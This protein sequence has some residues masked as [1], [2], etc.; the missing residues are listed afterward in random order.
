MYKTYIITHSPDYLLAQIAT[1]VLLRQ[2]FDVAWAVDSKEDLPAPHNDIIRTYEKRGGNLNGGTKWVIEQLQLMYDNANG[3]EWVIKVDSDTLILDRKWFDEALA[4]GYE[5]IG[6][7]SSRRQMFG[8]CYCIKVSLIPSLIELAEE[9]GDLNDIAAEDLIVAELL[10]KSGCRYL[11]SKYA[12]QKG[13]WGFWKS[14]PE[15]EERMAKK[16]QI[17][18]VQ[19]AAFARVGQERLPVLK[20]M[21]QIALAKFPDL[22]IY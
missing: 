6:F 18:C 22:E 21:R 1:K 5:A 2:G 14:A 15:I 11:R 7:R 17:I 3:A 13:V 4:E 9:N 20:A 10:K 16:F 19:R 8:F 12:P